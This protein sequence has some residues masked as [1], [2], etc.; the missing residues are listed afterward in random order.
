MRDKIETALGFLKKGQSFKVGGLKLGTYEN[1]LYV[2]GWS[3][4][5]YIENLTKSIALNELT[6]IKKQF[7][8]LLNSSLALKT[9]VKDKKIEYNLSFNFG[10]GSI[11]VC[12][13]TETEIIWHIGLDR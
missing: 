11:G 5:F 10:Q 7:K 2:V 4:Y 8:D 3:Q 12:S 13:E 9:F 1:G 6:A